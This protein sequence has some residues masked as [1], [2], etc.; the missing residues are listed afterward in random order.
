MA[1]KKIALEVEVKTGKGE[2]NVDDLKQKFEELRAE[3]DGYKKATEDAT[4]KMEA[5]FK[6]GKQGADAS[7]K[8]VQ[9]FG[10]SIG[11]AIK[12]LGLLGIALAVFDFLKDLLM[13]N[14]KVMRVFNK[15]LLTIEI[16]FS[17][18][19][20]A[21]SSLITN[22]KNL[23]N[24]DLAS[25]AKAF[26][27]FGKDLG[28]SADGAWELAGNIDELRKKVEIGA[29]AQA[30]ATLQF[31]R[32]AEIERQIR[33][34][35]SLSIEERLAANE[36]LGDILK[37]QMK[38]EL[39]LAGQRKQ[40]ALLEASF[41]QDKTASQIAILEAETAILEVEERITSQES[42][43]K[44]NRE[45]LRKENDEYVSS[46]TDLSFAARQFAF[47]QESMLENEGNITAEFTKRRDEATEEYTEHLRNT[48]ELLK[49][50]N[51]QMTA[52]QIEN[53]EDMI[54]LEEAHN[55]QLAR[56]DM[57]E[58]HAHMQIQEAKLAAASGVLG[59]MSDI[60][61]ATGDQSKEAVIAQKVLAIAQIAIDTAV[62]VSGA[63]RQA[64][65]AGPWPANLAAIAS[66]VA[67]V[68]SGIASAT[69]ILNKADVPGPSANISTSSIATSA[70][71]GAGVSTNT[72]QLSDQSVNQAELAPIQAFVVET[73]LTG[74]QGNVS[75]LQQQATFP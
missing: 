46:L 32:D 17:K 16:T 70:P 75:Q 11:G 12:A 67:A 10:K 40:L 6:A 34:N 74:S 58:L 59:A 9:G 4:K 65:N 51:S 66:G 61:T 30:K 18:V 7:A 47:E 22:L 43:Q 52:E 21:V 25:I 44:T 8:G 63:I 19:T 73:E 41:S 56:I 27:D 20:D 50:H 38:V 14:E 54:R 45:A 31:Q 69:T 57:E 68:L 72:T 71:T 36:R 5:G 64:Q 24:F 13:K 26:R 55:I 2:D 15:V 53:H 60:I 49:L 28:D 23:K 3:V 39:G 62:A 33:D 1:T 37:E 29:A 42:E 48:R 35:I